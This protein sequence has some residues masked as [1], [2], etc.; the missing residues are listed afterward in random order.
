MDKMILTHRIYKMKDSIDCNDKDRYVYVVNV[1]GGPFFFSPT[2]ECRSL[3]SWDDDIFSIYYTD[4]N[5]LYE[6]VE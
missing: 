2:V 1:D 6:L 4:F 3:K 5:E